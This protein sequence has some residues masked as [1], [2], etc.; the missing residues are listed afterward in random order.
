LASLQTNIGRLSASL[1]EANIFCETKKL[2]LKLLLARYS[3]AVVVN[4]LMQAANKILEQNFHFNDLNPSKIRS[5]L[6]MTLY[7]KFLVF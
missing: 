2:K 1:I 6:W 4:T 3:K 5:F 7:F